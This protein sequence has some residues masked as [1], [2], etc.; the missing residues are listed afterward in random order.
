MGAE[1]TTLTPDIETIKRLE[2]GLLYAQL[3]QPER[4]R[5]T[6][7]IDSTADI[8]DGFIEMAHTAV[9]KV[10]EEPKK[11]IAA[12]TLVMSAATGIGMVAQ[13]SPAAAETVVSR[14]GNTLIVEPSP[15]DTAYGITHKRDL[16]TSALE[17]KDGQQLT[18]PNL[19]K[20]GDQYRLVLPAPQTS[21]PQ[22]SVSHEFTAF[23]NDSLWHEWQVHGQGMPFKKFIESFKVENGT[24]FLMAGRRYKYP[25]GISGTPNDNGGSVNVPAGAGQWIIAKAVHDQTG[26][27]ISEVETEVYRN[28]G[29]V[30]HPDQNVYLSQLKDPTVRF[31]VQ[32][33]LNA[34]FTHPAPSRP[35]SPPAPTANAA[36]AVPKVAEAAPAAPNQL[37]AEAGFTI[38]T[39]KQLSYKQIENIRNHPITDQERQDAAAGKITR[40]YDIRTPSGLTA[41]QVEQLLPPAMK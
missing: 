16:P 2:Q 17:Q 22:P 19:I 12:S 6:D 28:G 23:P 35:V 36:S 15:G 18:R 10:V 9:N 1:G 14:Q 26:A 4:T 31:K 33:E 25:E 41:E 40:L 3:T 5:L 20:V 32:A 11:A 37:S 30:L 8:A 34:R 39:N 13:A 29:E 27:P 24:T 7:A 21:S 38:M